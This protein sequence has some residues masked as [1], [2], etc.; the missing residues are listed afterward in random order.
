LEDKLNRK[1]AGRMSGLRKNAGE[2]CELKGEP[3]LSGLEALR[4]MGTYGMKIVWPQG[5]YRK[6]KFRRGGCWDEGDGS[7]VS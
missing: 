1:G 7:S 6:E 4:L 3:A 5:P 2:K